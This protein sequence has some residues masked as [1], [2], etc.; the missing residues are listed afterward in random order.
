MTMRRTKPESVPA[1]RKGDYSPEEKERIVD[2]VCDEL[3]KKRSLFSILGEDAGMPSYATFMKW[4]RD[5]ETISQQVAHAREAALE[6]IIEEIIEISDAD[7]GDAYIY[8]DPKTG[9]QWAKID[10]D[11]VQR[12]KLRVY[13]REKVAQMLAP[14][15][16]GVQRM[17]VTSDG[18]QISNETNVTLVENRVASILM[19]AQRR[20]EEQKQLEQIIDVELD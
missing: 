19:V 16:F 13:A 15:R 5:S 10:G 4:Q 17:D 1:V 20:I 9:K 12:A 8:T 14:R 18:K 2:Y 3:V 7:A 11:C 6:A